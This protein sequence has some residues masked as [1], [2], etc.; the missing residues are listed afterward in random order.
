[1]PLIEAC[2]AEQSIRHRLQSSFLIDPDLQVRERSRSS[3]LLSVPSSPAQLH[4]RLRAIIAWYGIDNVG[5]TALLTQLVAL[6][7]WRMVQVWQFVCATEEKAEQNRLEAGSDVLELDRMIRLVTLSSQLA[8]D[9]ALRLDALLMQVSQEIAD[10]EEAIANGDSDFTCDRLDR[11]AEG[12]VEIQKLLEDLEAEQLS[13]E[14]AMQEA[15]RRSGEG[16]VVG[17]ACSPIAEFVCYLLAWTNVFAISLYITTLAPSNLDMWLSCY[18]CLQGSQVLLEIIHCRG[19]INFLMSTHQPELRLRRRLHVFFVGCSLWGMILFILREDG[20]NR[21]FSGNVERFILSLTCL[22]VFTRNPYFGQMLSQLSRSVIV[23]Y[24]YLAITFITLLAFAQVCRDVYHD[25]DPKG[26]FKD[27]G[28]SMVYMLQ[29]WTGNGFGIMWDQWFYTNYASALLFNAYQFFQ[30]LLF[31]NL[32]LGVIIGIFSEVEASGSARVYDALRALNLDMTEAEKEGLL[33]DFLSINWMLLHVHSKIDALE[34]FG[35]DALHHSDEAQDESDEEEPK[36]DVGDSGDGAN[37]RGQDEG[38][39][40][41]RAEDKDALVTNVQPELPDDDGVNI[42]VATPEVALRTLTD[43]QL[44]SEQPSRGGGDHMSLEQGSADIKEGAADVAPRSKT[45]SS[46]GE[47]C[48]S[49][50]FMP[51]TWGVCD[52]GSRPE[53]EGDAVTV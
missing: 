50:M 1:M 38:S 44:S 16:S 40:Y 37:H 42:N 10:V 27:L 12:E 30:A 36:G 22:M 25:S 24:P 26:Y 32:V 49:D 46:Q 17:F 43:R 51:S 33:A 6:H 4:R 11:I 52:P 2:R 20:A 21:L 45:S 35:E 18:P 29:I 15:M 7:R 31:S 39:F 28:T 19:L 13:I 9:S 47:V 34:S 41:P 5:K 48:G 14:G 53:P 23:C 8:V 3:L